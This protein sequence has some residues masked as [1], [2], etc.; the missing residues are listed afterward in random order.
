MGECMPIK[1]TID[2]KLLV[3]ALIIS[4]IIFI[5][6]VSVGYGVNKEKLSLIEQDMNNIVADVQNFQLQ[7]LFIEVLCEDST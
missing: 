3:S 5:A 1:K 6:G 2:V 4:A 7:T